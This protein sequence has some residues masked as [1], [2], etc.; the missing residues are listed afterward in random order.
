[1]DLWRAR[2]FARRDIPLGL[3]GWMAFYPF[4]VYRHVQKTVCELVT[5]PYLTTANQRA[6]RPDRGE[7]G[8]APT[9]PS[10][11]AE[12]TKKDPGPV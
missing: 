3:R 4:G 11:K 8:E 2:V 9:S 7:A 1:M 10:F 6:T 5:C 12:L